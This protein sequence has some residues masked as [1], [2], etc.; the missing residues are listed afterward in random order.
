MKDYDWSYLTP[1]W[2]LCLDAFLKHTLSHSGSE[3]SRGTYEDILRRFFSGSQPDEMNRED[4]R[5]FLDEP[6]QGCRNP[7]AVC[8]ASTIN[9][10]TMVI[11]SWY[12]FA[13]MFEVRTDDGT[14]KPIFEQRSP[15]Y[16]FRYLKTGSPNKNMSEEEITRFFAAIPDD[17]RGCRNRCIFLF[18]FMTCRR[19][20]E[21]R[22]MRW[23]DIQA[24][25]IVADASGNT[26]PGWIFRH[27]D[28]GT[29]RTERTSELPEICHTAIVTMLTR[30]GRMDDIQPS[31]YLF[32]AI[33]QGTMRRD[34]PITG[35]YLNDCFHE[36]ATLAQ[37]RPGLSFHSLRHAGASARV[38]AGEPLPSL[39]RILSHSNLASTDRYVRNI[40]E[41]SDA[42]G[43][44]L[45]TQFHYLAHH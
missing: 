11:N 26:R 21:I 28:K 43:L 25:T 30:Q 34:R 45:Q 33:N 13:A 9:Q 1:Q 19:S 37:L 42:Y 29:S 24:A 14:Y 20:D 17:V 36:Y 22:R 8:N 16:G 3:K 5:A 41:V 38:R 7:G 27:R 40:M 6:C 2:K 23:G 39:M 10:K 31:D 44:K 32:M 15:S 18:A 4:V 12:K 35:Y